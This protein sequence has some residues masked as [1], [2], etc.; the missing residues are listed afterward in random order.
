MAGGFDTLRWRDGR[1]ELLDQRALPERCSYLA[2]DTAAAIAQAIRSMVVRGAPAIGCAAAYGVAL[3]ARRLRDR[4]G[5]EFDAMMEQAF[6]TL[7]QS[8]PTAVNLFWALER[9]RNRLAVLRGA[10]PQTTAAA[11][12]D[13][14]H[15]IREEDVRLNRAL[16]RHGSALLAD[17][18]RV[19]THCNAG[20]LATAG[21]GTALG[22]IRSAV[23][24]GK[25]IR[26]LADE[27]RPFLQG[28]RLTAWELQQDA[29][30]VTVIADNAA[31]FLMSRGEVDA[32]IVG[33]DR[34]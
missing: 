32:V 5:P 20:A 26:V 34:V 17:G 30:P 31:G 4:P 19:L 9:M 6:E 14:A 23:E 10:D 25:R 29:I 21:H 27:T 13:E 24:S 16:G 1:L 15:A 28:A 2:F 33:A 11:L 22:V 7:G 8:R 18:A 12:L 3:E